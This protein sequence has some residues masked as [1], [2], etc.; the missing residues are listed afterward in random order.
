MIQI[1]TTRDF[2]VIFNAYSKFEEQVVNKSLA[3]QTGNED[4][5]ADEENELELQIEKLVDITFDRVSEKELDN[6]QMEDHDKVESDPDFV[7]YRVE[8]LLERRPFLLSHVILRQNP[9][10]VY[11][12]LNLAKLCEVCEYF[13]IIF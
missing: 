2:G 13:F 3:A 8:N 4:E 5:A 9:N 12:W 7:M 10:N 11:E 1:S 6:G